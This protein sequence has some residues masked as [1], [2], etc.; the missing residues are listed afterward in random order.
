MIKEYLGDIKSGAFPL[1]DI[2]F[3][4]YKYHGYLIGNDECWDMDDFYQIF[5]DVNT[6]K[7]YRMYFKTVPGVDLDNIDY[8][9]PA[10]VVDEE[11]FDAIRNL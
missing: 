5:I 9:K 2:E 3:D 4:D 6:K 1:I 10:Y 7:V 11:D 8:L